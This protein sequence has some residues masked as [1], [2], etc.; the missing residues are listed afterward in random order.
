MLARG[1]AVDLYLHI[2]RDV[3]FENGQSGRWTLTQ[4][5]SGTL[6]MP[7]RESLI[8]YCPDCGFEPFQ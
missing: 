2:D 7:V 3:V 4:A 8:L 6:A 5:R 1:V